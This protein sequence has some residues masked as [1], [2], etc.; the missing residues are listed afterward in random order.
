[1]AIIALTYENGVNK[2]RYF[3]WVGLGQ[4]DSGQ[5]AECPSYMDK[6]L[7]VFGTFGATLTIQGS[8]DPRVASDPN[9]AVWFTLVDPHERDVTATSAKAEVLLENPRFI[10][11]LVTGGDG[12][13]D[14]T[15]IMCARK[16]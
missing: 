8:N 9:N 4:G 2:T 14:I 10:R 11:P 6:T 15:A 12:S 13:T 1:M 5:P 3:S 7:Q 16:G